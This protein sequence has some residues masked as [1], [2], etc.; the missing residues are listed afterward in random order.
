MR[1]LPLSCKIARGRGGVT[2]HSE[3]RDLSLR[4]LPLKLRYRRLRVDCP[5]R[6]VRVEDFPSA[7][8]WARVELAGY[9]ASLRAELESVAIVVK[10]AVQ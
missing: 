6:G 2:G 3:W 8:P 4:R 10:R 7:E 1:R 9:R 5:R